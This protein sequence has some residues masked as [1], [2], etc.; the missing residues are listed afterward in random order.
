MKFA[1]APNET[2]DH[3]CYHR[4]LAAFAQVSKGSVGVILFSQNQITMAADSREIPVLGGPRRVG[5]FSL[6]GPITPNDRR[7]KI[8]ALDDQ[9]V[10]VSVGMTGYVGD[11]LV[12]AWTNADEIRLVYGEIFETYHTSAGHTKEISRKWG[13]AVANHFQMA[14]I[15]NPR[16]FDQARQ[17]AS[18]A[19][20]ITQA[21]IGGR[22]ESGNL[23]LF[24]VRI[25]T[26]SSIL[27]VHGTAPESIA[28]G[29]LHVIG[30]TDA[31]NSPKYFTPVPGG[32]HIPDWSFNGDEIALAEKLADLTIKYH[33]S[34]TTHLSF[35]S[36]LHGPIDSL[37]FYRSQ[38]HC[39]FHR[40]EN[41]PAN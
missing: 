8:T 15:F 22:L 4:S 38:G 11:R 12:R 27:G 2:L 20:E 35:I 13:I 10:F 33:D 14:S 17:S 26:G 24:K 18:L 9:L 29:D 21:Y 28:F 23:L 16:V 1:R 6:V 7:C 30:D 31:I 32:F 19:G 34:R 39:W 37:Q 40:K 41:C 5:S 36:N 3:C 25:M